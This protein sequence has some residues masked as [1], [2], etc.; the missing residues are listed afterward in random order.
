MTLG[1]AIGYSSLIGL[2]AVPVLL[3]PGLAYRMKVEERLLTEQFGEDYRTYIR[4]SKKLIPGSR[5]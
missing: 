2:A 5:Q 1:V 4:K 3:L